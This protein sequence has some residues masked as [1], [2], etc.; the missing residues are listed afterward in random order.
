MKD[1]YS[2]FSKFRRRLYLRAYFLNKPNREKFPFH[3]PSVWEPPIPENDNITQYVSRVYNDL[4]YAQI[5]H[6]LKS[7]LSSE[8]IN[9]LDELKSNT[10]IIIKPADKGGKIV[11]WD[12][13]DY[14]KEA[15]RQLNDQTYYIQI[16]NDPFVDLILEISTFI[17]YLYRH[18]HINYQLFLFL[19][20][21]SSARI[22]LFYLLPKIHKPG[23]PGRP[24]ISGCDSPTTKLSI[25]IDYYLKPMV[26]RIPS[27]IQ[28]NTFP[29]H[30][31]RFCWYHTAKLYFSDFRC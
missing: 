22:P 14:I 26:K 8:E 12:R 30:I 17:S 28:D 11:I 9:A 2:A 23:T 16:N 31:A 24:I 1:I 19:D 27:Y 20:P 7:N 18:N 29:T 6:T 4:N 21:K 3:L 13:N 10:H 5:P 15:H 25:F